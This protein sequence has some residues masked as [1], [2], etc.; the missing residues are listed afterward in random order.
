MC[1]GARNDG[2]HFKGFDLAFGL[3]GVGT[4]RASGAKT[5]ALWHPQHRGDRTMQPAARQW[6]KIN[7]KRSPVC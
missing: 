4:G 5:A 7:T 3:S 2:Q 6:T 1:A